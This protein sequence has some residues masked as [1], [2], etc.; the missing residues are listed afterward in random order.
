MLRATAPEDAR[1]WKDCGES[2]ETE[3]LEMLCR[4]RGLVG[5]GLSRNEY[6]PRCA[7]GSKIEGTNHEAVWELPEGAC[8]RGAQSTPASAH[9]S[10]D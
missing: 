1:V 9:V 2:L 4:E 3:S 8:G 6:G 10:K 5:Q 7:L